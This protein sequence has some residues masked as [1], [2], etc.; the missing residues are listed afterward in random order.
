MGVPEFKYIPYDGASIDRNSDDSDDSSDARTVSSMDSDDSSSSSSGSESRLSDL[1]AWMKMAPGFQLKKQEADKPVYEAWTFYKAPD[2]E[3]IIGR[4]KAKLFG[5]NGIR[6]DAETNDCTQG[7]TSAWPEVY[8]QSEL[9]A[10]HLDALSAYQ[11]KNKRTWPTRMLRNKAKTYEE[12]LNERC[13]KLPV[14]IQDKIG[15][16][17]SDRGR[18]SSSKYRIRTWTV[19]VVRENLRRRFAGAGLTEVERHKVR[20]WKNPSSKEPIQYTVVIRGSEAKACT[21]RKGYSIPSPNLNPWE[22]V[23][24]AEATRKKREDRVRRAEKWKKSHPSP[25]SYHTSRGSSP[26]APRAG[27]PK[28][29]MP[30]R[31]FPPPPSM[32]VFNRPPMMQAPGGPRPPGSM[33]PRPE[34]FYPPGY[35]SSTTPSPPISALPPQVCVACR[36]TVRCQH[37]S[38][39]LTCHRPIELYGNLPIH[40]PCF[41]CA[42]NSARPAGI[43]YMKPP[44]Q[45]PLGSVPQ[46]MRPSPM[47]PPMGPPPMPNSGI[48]VPPPPPPPFYGRGVDIVDVKPGKRHHRRDEDDTSSET[49]LDDDNDSVSSSDDEDEKRLRTSSLSPPITLLPPPPHELDSK[50]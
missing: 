45:M 31:T 34:Q 41:L 50:P 26:V 36:S 14:I 37:F 6:V 8:E 44:R 1:A 19:V 35:Q 43:H 42:N 30:P 32:A 15:S 21:D 5:I 3:K 39:G 47:G 10:M 25:P 17:L 46:A 4:G 38:Q 12:D 16:L 48:R 22:N 49:T 13:G 23:D 29:P 24:D 2:K 18:N 9:S 7:V 11:V 20:F 28:A 27:F 33:P 40:S